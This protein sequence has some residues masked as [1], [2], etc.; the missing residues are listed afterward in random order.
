MQ[1]M[2][3]MPR[4]DESR[5]R[6]AEGGPSYG[7]KSKTD[8]V[9]LYAQRCCSNFFRLVVAMN[10]FNRFDSYC[11]GCCVLAGFLLNGLEQKMLPVFHCSVKL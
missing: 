8:P 6:K 10:T 11:L 7:K 3:C 1:V 9:V 5:K 2:K 4:I